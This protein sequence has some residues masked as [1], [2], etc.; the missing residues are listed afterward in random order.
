MSENFPEVKIVEDGAGHG[1]TFI[2]G[3]EFGGVTAFEVMGAVDGITTVR[4]T[5][6]A[7]SIEL[8]SNI[9][10]APKL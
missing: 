6:Y 5:F 4:L 3:K 10:T 2:D 1:R 9:E 7:K 8:W